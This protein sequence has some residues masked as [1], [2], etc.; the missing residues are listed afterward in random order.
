MIVYASHY[1]IYALFY[2][3]RYTLT[4]FLMKHSISYSSMPFILSRRFDYMSIH[5]L[6]ILYCVYC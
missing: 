5:I 2:T 3:W 6:T 1:E 4:L